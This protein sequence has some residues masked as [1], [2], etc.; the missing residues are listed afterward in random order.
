MTQNM[1]G[2]HSPFAIAFSYRRIYKNI[3][4]L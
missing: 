3:S 1:A 4:D 2:F